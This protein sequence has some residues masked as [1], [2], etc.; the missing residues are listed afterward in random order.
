MKSMTKFTWILILPI[1]LSGCAIYYHDTNTGAEHI[2]GFGHLATKVTP[3][4]D[5]KQAIIRQSTLTGLAVG[6]EDE[7]FGFSVGYDRRE[8]ITVYDANSTLAIQRPTSNNFI[9]FK[10]GSY[11]EQTTAVDQHK[12]LKP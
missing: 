5:G 4:S 11:P 10:I 1:L 2:W 3:P 8:R 12:S 6:I 9:L 7:A